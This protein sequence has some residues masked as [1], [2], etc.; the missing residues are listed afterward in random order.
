MGIGGI[1]MSGIAEILR[2]R[3]YTVSGCDLATGTKTLQH[4]QTIGCTI[5]HKHADWHVHDADVLVYSSAVNK[6][7]G[8]VLA[9]LSKGIPVIAR[10][11]MLAELMRSKFSV[12][13]SGAHGKTTTTSLISHIMIEAG[14]QPTIVVGGVVKNMANNA[15]LGE[16]E[17]FI[18]E[19]DESD[20]SLLYLS[21]SVAVVTNIDAEHLDTYKDL[22]DIK[23]TFK[24][25]LARIPFYGKAFVCLDDQNIRSILPL[26]HV[27]TVAYGLSSDADVMGD[28][29]V[30]DATSSS[31]DV[32]ERS[33]PS[34]GSGRALSE[35]DSVK[36]GAHPELVEGSPIFKKEK[37][38]LGRITASI[39]GIHNVRNCLAAIAVCREF[40]V[41]F[42][43][44]SQALATF[45]GVERRFEF[46]GTIKGA[47]IFDD[48]GHHPVE[49]KSTLLVA[50]KR[51]NKRLHVVFQPHRF[52]RT[53]KLWDDFVNV[54]ADHQQ[55]G[56]PISTLYITD[57]YPASEAPI[58]GITS[59]K[60]V[61]VIKEKKPSSTS[62]LCFNV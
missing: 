54:F 26:Q 44:I 16:G 24:D 38:F 39:P 23:N 49:I 42:A 28:N 62:P 30:L 15:Q 32:Y 40:D 60:L 9:A 10:A 18:A 7:D 19:A 29:V 22:D 27:P 46:K 5:H 13:I 45:K 43:V 34:T 55:D 21:P 3:G 57:I 52:T 33:C 53:E 41:S 12:A 6:Q 1:G 14:K 35:K 58:P 2:L 37:K 25:F 51:A 47:E 31:F 61:S 48:Y 11:I 8:E 36:I 4:L 20:R 56:Y 50:K 59:E 17:I